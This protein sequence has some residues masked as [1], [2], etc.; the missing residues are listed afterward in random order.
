M[1]FWM[2]DWLKEHKYNVIF[3]LF[4]AILFCSPYLFRNGLPIEHD[5]FFHL[6]R[7]EH[8]SISL[9]NLNILPAIYPYENAGFGYGS[10]LFYSDILLF[11]PSFLRLLG[12]PLVSSY[13]FFIFL[14]TIISSISIYLLVNKVTKNNIISYLSSI[15]YIFNNYRITDVYIRSALGEIMA[16]SFLPLLLLSIYHLFYEKDEKKWPLLYLSLCLLV[17]SHNLTFIISVILFI[18]FFII[19]LPKMNMQ[20]FKYTIL[21]CFLAF[22]S[23]SFFTL[24]MLEQLSSQEFMV[25]NHKTTSFL[26]FYSMDLWQYFA[27]KTVFALAG[28]FLEGETMVV[29]IGYFLTFIPLLYLFLK[30]EKTTFLTTLLILGYIFM[31]LP[32][33]YIP[34]DKLSFISVL[35][36]PW[37]LNTIATLL[38]T[39]VSTY[40]IYTLI[41][42]KKIILV[43]IAL[44][45]IEGIYH[46]IPDFD[47]SF[48]MNENMT[49]KQV[50]NGEL[51]NPYYSADYMRIELAGGEYLPKNYTSFIDYPFTVRNDKNEI[52]DT[53]IRQNYTTLDISFP[54]QVYGPYTLP[55]T[56]YKGYQV[57]DEEG[58]KL[59]TFETNNG[60]VGFNANSHKQYKCKYENTT[61]RSLSIF[62]SLLS[63]ILSIYAIKRSSS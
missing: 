12:L 47:R 44:L 28:N 33:S 19:R 26:S 2:I 53:S 31:M 16:I 62:G 52:V 20:I 15:V 61:L 40:A 51:T 21:A 8:N 13:K 9:K 42:N 56:Y 27:N 57:Y 43:V 41:K 49:W 55:I 50:Q 37:R 18:I 48:V 10:P 30:E 23:T 6:S 46:I 60:F 35:Q 25:S 58:N 22:L 7:I 29:N 63:L 24:P 4:I 14:L 32:S 54:T 38:L 1:E 5:T 45:L 3:H 34:W 59:D 11:I 39:P 17:L 36:F